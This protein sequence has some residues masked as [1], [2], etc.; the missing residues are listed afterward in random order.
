[1]CSSAS[2]LLDNDGMCAATTELATL[3]GRLVEEWYAEVLGA[4]DMV[5]EHGNEESWRWEEVKTRRDASES[6]SHSE[7]ENSATHHVSVPISSPDCTVAMHLD[8]DS[9]SSFRLL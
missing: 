9:S 8:T 1:M 7:K 3:T 6:D 4:E 5:S 2:R